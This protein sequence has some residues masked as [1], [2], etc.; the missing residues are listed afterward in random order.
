MKLLIVDDE[1]M[2]KEYT[3]YVIQEEGFPVL[4]FEASNGE[5]A[6]AMA[7]KVQP[8]AIFMDI[9]MPQ[10]NGLE[11]MEMIKKSLPE[12]IVVF[13]SAYDKFEYAQKALRLGALDYIL[14]PIN[15]EDLKGLLKRLLALKQQQEPPE[16][17]KE[18]VEDDLIVKAKEYVE[19]NY[20]NKIHLQDVSEYVGLSPTYFSKFFK[21]KT[22]VN[23]SNYLNQVR[24]EKAKELMKNPNLSIYQISY[25]VGYEDVS[26]FSIVF[27]KYT[28]ITPTGY[29]RRLMTK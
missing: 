2:M 21:K 9:K 17:K 18:T 16:V 15:P 11:A 8:D 13:L 3:K 5:E 14:K 26:Y 29:R 19:A 24:I 6:I 1:R 7:E 28:G 20:Q 22:E 10:V 25:T 4:V 12:A 27:Q 23:F